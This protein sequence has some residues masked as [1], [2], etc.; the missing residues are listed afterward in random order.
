MALGYTPNTGGRPATEGTV[1]RKRRPRAV[2]EVFVSS[3]SSVYL[4]D[5]AHP[6]EVPVDSGD[7]AGATTRRR[8]AAKSGSKGSPGGRLD[9]VYENCVP[10]HESRVTRPRPL[11]SLCAV[12][13][14][15]PD[16]RGAGL[17]SKTPDHRP[18]DVPPRRKHAAKVATPQPVIASEGGEGDS[19]RFELQLV[20]AF[21]VQFSWVVLAVVAVCSV[22]ALQAPNPAQCVETSE[23]YCVVENVVAPPPYGPFPPNATAVWIRNSSLPTVDRSLF[24]ALPTAESLMIHRL[25]VEHLS[26]DGCPR[27][28]VLFAS[29]NAIKRIDAVEGLPLRQLHLYQNRLTDIGG[30]RRLTALEQLYLH[31]NLLESLALEQLAPL[32]KLKILTLQRNR[33]TTLGGV[34]DPPLVMPHLEQLFLQFNQLP[35]LDTSLW[36]MERLRALDLSHNR[37]GFLMTFLEELPA[38]RTLELHHNPW[39]CA[40][41]AGMLDRVDGR[42]QMAPAVQEDE[43]QCAAGPLLD[44][45]L[46]CAENATAPDPMLLLVTRTGIVDELQQQ[47][48]GARDQIHALEERERKQDALF[49]GLTKRLDQIEQLCAANRP[50]A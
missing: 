45:R 6:P 17:P 50:E 31:E 25:R 38:L 46:C 10:S 29:Y 19:N 28:E 35:H 24:A 11:T 36:R 9:P 33:L 27:L 20:S 39:N 30:V 26:L 18:P 41:L 12:R 14:R 4:C 8:A 22:A 34:R 23:G 16:N 37:L 43:A 15:Q 21:L 13:V 5:P 42:H 2:G 48:H 47:I 3:T 32:G 40:W 1:P 44:G 7:V 49:R